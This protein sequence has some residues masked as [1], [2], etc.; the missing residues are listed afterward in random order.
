M[1]KQ[2]AILT[3]EK[4]TSQLKN[5]RN[6]NIDK[7]RQSLANGPLFKG[8]CSLGSFNHLALKILQSYQN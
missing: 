7:I 8:H 4:L 3:S 6:A 2:R 5:V 1:I